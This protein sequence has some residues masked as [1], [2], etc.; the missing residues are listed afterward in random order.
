MNSNELDPRWLKNFKKIK[1]QP[2]IKQ[3]SSRT[4]QF[5]TN[6]DRPVPYKTDSLK[7]SIWHKFRIW[8]CYVWYYLLIYLYIWEK[9]GLRKKRTM[10]MFLSNPNVNRLSI[11]SKLENFPRRTRFDPKIQTFA[12]LLPLGGFLRGMEK[13]RKRGGPG[14][15]SLKL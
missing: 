10:R 14:T 8:K 13:T 6:S 7:C 3:G 11:N 2:G 1:L 12:E 15:P 9:Y 4:E 5:R